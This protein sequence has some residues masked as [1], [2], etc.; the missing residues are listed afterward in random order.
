MKT[1]LM[2]QQRNIHTARGERGSDDN[3]IEKVDMLIEIE[4]SL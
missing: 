1:K 3:I 2:H 4:N